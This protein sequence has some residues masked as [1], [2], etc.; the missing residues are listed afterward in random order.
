[1]VLRPNG[2]PSSALGP[3]FRRRRVVTSASDS[4]TQAP[5]G[6]FLLLDISCPLLSR[7]IAL[8]LILSLP[9]LSPQPRA[10]TQVCTL[11]PCFCPG[12]D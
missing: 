9:A 3:W 4:S 1:M 2:E 12:P 6:L 8:S 10:C 5:R 7:E 11:H